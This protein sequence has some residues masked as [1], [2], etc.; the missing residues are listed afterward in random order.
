MV[1]IMKL[2][3]AGKAGLQHLHVELRGDSLDMIEASS[4]RRTHDGAPAQKLSLAWP[5][6]SAKPAMAR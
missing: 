3:D 1:Q 5:L 2:A 4:T 6:T